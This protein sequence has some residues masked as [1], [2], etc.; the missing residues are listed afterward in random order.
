MPSLF[1]YIDPFTGALLYQL[2]VAGVVAAALFFK[3]VKA[4][5]L[6]TFGFGVAIDMESKPESADIPTI[7]LEQTEQTEKEA[8]KAA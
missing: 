8:Q 5:V 7:K 4:F 3:R 6:G 1:A 2:I